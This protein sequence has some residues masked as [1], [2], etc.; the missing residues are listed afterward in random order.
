MRTAATMKHERRL[1]V[2]TAATLLVLLCGCRAESQFIRED[3]GAPTA[4][5]CPVDR[6]AYPWPQQEADFTPLAHRIAPPEGFDRVDTERASWAEWLR[7]LPVCSPGTRVRDLGGSAIVAA[8]L[9]APAAVLDM[10]V[11]KYQECADVILRLRAEYLL[12]SG[13]ESEIVFRLTGPGSISWPEWKQGM[14]PKYDGRRLSFSRTAAP[15]SSRECFD[16]YLHSVFEWCGTLSLAKEGRP[17]GE[18]AP[19]IGDFF[20]RG[21]SPGHAA[22]I[23]DL[24]VDGT[25]AYRALIAHG[26]MPAQSP[27]VLRTPGGEDWF[28]LSRHTPIRL[29]IWGS[30]TWSELRRFDD[31]RQ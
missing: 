8:N 28:D 26:Y 10:D 24:A 4:L 11:R 18:G 17:V 20:V 30:F 21:G 12:Q 25:G 19:R 15:C 6:S 31:G 29:P 2:A 22:V 13:R 1:H 27:H 7:Y 23:V 16:R 5:P 3:P 14:R 9:H